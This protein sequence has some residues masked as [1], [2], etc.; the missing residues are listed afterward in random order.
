MLRVLRV[1]QRDQFAGCGLSIVR[2]PTQRYAT[3]VGVH[4]RN[5][6]FGIRFS[7][8]PRR[9]MF[10]ALHR[11]RC[12]KLFG[13]WQNPARR[14]LLATR[15]GYLVAGIARTPTCAHY[16]GVR[17]AEIELARLEAKLSAVR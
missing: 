7:C 13:G 11:S 4:N 1:R 17:I 9:E 10:W 14:S 16:R 3:I 12:S 6:V 2:S 15:H 5:S 8:R